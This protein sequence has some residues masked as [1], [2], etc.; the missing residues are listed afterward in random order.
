MKKI[1]ITAGLLVSMLFRGSAQSSS[2]DES[3]Y[4]KRKL[5]VD[6]VNFISSYY[7]QEGNNSAVTGGIGTEKLTDYANS[8]DLKMSKYDL[9]SRLH[10]FTI[11]FNVDYY[12]SASS[13]NIDPRS[14]S[15]ASSRDM[16]IYPSIAW[17]MKDAKT[18]VTKGLAYSYSTEFDYQSHGFTASWAKASRDNNREFS[19]KASAFLD[20]ATIIL[21]NELRTITNAVGRSGTS[22]TKPRNSYALALSLSQVIN[23]RLQLMLVAEPSYQEG[24]LSTSFHR[25]YFTDNTMT[26]EKLPGS[27]FK[28]PIGIRASY[29]LGDNIVL[30]GFYRYYMD[31]WG[32][33]ANTVNLEG[34][35]KVTPFVSL[36]PFYRFSSQKAVKYFAPYGQHLATDTYYTSDYDISGMNT[37]FVGSGVRFAPVNGV[38]GMKHWS[39]VELRYG[40]YSR[41]TGM[42]ANIVTLHLKM[43]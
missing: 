6:E 43:K 15:G 1:I 38:L 32:M 18:R 39:S 28:L 21:P 13:D 14:I 25:V 31:N 33:T 24:F 17:S 30:K 11:D 16:H 37:N 3:F 29:F 40:H 20:K 36:T 35:Y 19:I 7:H 10:S 26:V 34:S 23:E 41:T 9:K 2:E 42:V 4:E 27:R 8:F 22:G 5:K 12:T